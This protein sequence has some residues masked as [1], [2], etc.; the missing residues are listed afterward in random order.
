MH[1]THAPRCT[2]LILAA[3]PHHLYPKGLTSWF[4]FNQGHRLSGLTLLEWTQSWAK[5]WSR[6]GIS[7]RRNQS[8]CQAPQ[9][10]PSTWTQHPPLVQ[11]HSICGSGSERGG[12]KSLTRRNSGGT[13]SESK[14]GGISGEEAANPSK[15]SKQQQMLK[16]QCPST[17]SYSCNFSTAC[18]ATFRSVRLWVCVCVRSHVSARAW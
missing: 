18:R 8:L 7:P 5:E 17:K 3:R 14:P 2:R 1:H 15:Y 10:S 16:G 6:A 11:S 12:V 13:V 4:I 9:S